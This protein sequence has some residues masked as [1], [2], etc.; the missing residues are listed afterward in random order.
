MNTDGRDFRFLLRVLGIGA[1]ATLSL[2][3]LA[4]LVLGG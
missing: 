1:V 2:F 3:I 4:T